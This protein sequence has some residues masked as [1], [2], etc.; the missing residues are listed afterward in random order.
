MPVYEKN[1]DSA[2]NHSLY[3]I[4]KNPMYEHTSIYARRHCTY[5]KTQQ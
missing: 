2:K 5:I 1:N 3:I 4:T